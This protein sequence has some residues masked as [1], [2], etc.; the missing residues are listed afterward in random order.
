MR[1]VNADSAASIE[2]NLTPTERAIY[3]AVGLGL[4]AAATKPR[5]NPFLNAVALV[6][7]T[8]LAWRGYKGSCPIKGVLFDK[9]ETKPR[10]TRQD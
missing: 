5:P 6:G 2:Q 3:I 9:S 10:L 7:G 4:A 1:T 8:Y